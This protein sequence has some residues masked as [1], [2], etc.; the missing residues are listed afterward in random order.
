MIEVWQP[1]LHMSCSLIVQI[2]KWTGFIF[3]VQWLTY[4]YSALCDNRRVKQSSMGT[5]L[6]M[7]NQSWSLAIESRLERECHQR[8]LSIILIYPNVINVF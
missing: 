1:S 8:H 2:Q 4:I 3:K 6:F 5:R 7:G